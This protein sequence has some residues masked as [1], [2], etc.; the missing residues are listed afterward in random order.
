ML[1]YRGVLKTPINIFRMKKIILVLAV[2]IISTASI[3]AQSGFGVKAGLG[4]NSLGDVTSVD[5]DNIDET[6]NK[7]NGFHVGVAYKM[8]FILGLTLQPELLYNQ[9]GATVN[10]TEGSLK[11]KFDTKIGSLQLPVN[12]QWGLDLMLFRPYIFA[13]PYVSCALYNKSDLKNFEYEKFQYGVG[14]G[15]GIEIWKL[16][17]SG[18]YNWAGKGDLA[19]GIAAGKNVQF[20]KRGGFELSLAILF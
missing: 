8:N 3:F 15:A 17:L 13:A 20:E 10:V 2:S 7:N 16:Q 19:D 6:L 14:L 12:V 1:Y 9:S 18:K 11:D 4:F 5:L